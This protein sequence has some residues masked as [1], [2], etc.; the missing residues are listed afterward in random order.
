MSVCVLEQ[1]THT[2][3]RERETHVCGQKQHRCLSIQNIKGEVTSLGERRG[4][5]SSKVPGEG[6]GWQRGGGGDQ[7]AA[8]SWPGKA[9]RSGYWEA[10]RSG[11]R[12]AARC[13]NL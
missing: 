4:E 12:K 8:G 13:E 5:A 11:L 7:P 3:R 2:N 10:A 1:Q 9:A 6:T